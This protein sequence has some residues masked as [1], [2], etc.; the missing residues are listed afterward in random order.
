MKV[1]LDLI[2]TERSWSWS[3]VVIGYLVASM[4]VRQIVFRSVLKETKRLDSNVY[5]AVKKLYLRRSLVGWILFLLSV[6]LVAAVWIGWSGPTV[7]MGPLV[8]FSVV[9]LLLFFLS[10]I[11]HLVSYTRAVLEILGQRMGIEREL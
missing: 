4:V 10:I 7:E 11:L 3:I 8:S 1:Y 9:L 5:S 2:L 6:I